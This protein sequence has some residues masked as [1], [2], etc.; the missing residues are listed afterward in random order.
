MGGVEE[1]H[2]ITWAVPALQ[3][4]A[5][6]S[7]LTAVAPDAFLI[8][9]CFHSQSLWWFV[10]HSLHVANS[11][12]VGAGRGGACHSM[13]PGLENSQHFLAASDHL[14]YK[15]LESHWCLG[16]RGGV[17]SPFLTL[18][19][20]NFVS[21]IPG[22]SFAYRKEAHWRF[23]CFK[24]FW[25][26]VMDLW[27]NRK[28]KCEMIIPFPKISLEIILLGC[29]S[30]KE[31][32]LRGNWEKRRPYLAWYEHLLDSEANRVCA[33]CSLEVGWFLTILLNT[34]V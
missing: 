4:L 7:L 5:S 34:Y 21:N 28:W 2:L 14:P 19:I 23:Q 9:V 11:L 13:K 33:Q 20:L 3:E 8:E 16:T 31:K 15:L 27:K 25:A 32:R 18:S 6:E 12:W 30:L 1:T 10:L 17:S 26:K 29:S 22:K 24:E